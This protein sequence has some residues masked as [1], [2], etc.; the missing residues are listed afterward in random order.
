MSCHLRLIATITYSAYSPASRKRLGVG[1]A[2]CHFMFVNALGQ[3][4][5]TPWLPTTPVVPSKSHMT[6][7]T[8]ERDMELKDILIDIC[9]IR[10]EVL[11]YTAS[12]KGQ[13][14][15]QSSLETFKE[16]LTMLMD[17]RHIL[18]ATWEIVPPNLLYIKL[19]EFPKAK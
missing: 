7:K 8:I 15:W 4:C 17:A 12:I 18:Q 16:S 1:I 5:S 2:K 6:F 9:W 14:G 13:N 3:R 19:F 11:R 10:L